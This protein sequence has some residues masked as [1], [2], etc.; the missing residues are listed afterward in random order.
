MTTIIATNYM[1]EADEL[2]NKIAIINRGKLIVYEDINILKDS[3]KGD[4]ID[5][6]LDKDIEKV[7]NVLDKRKWVNSVEEYD[8]ILRIYVHKG[9][10]KI[11]R[12]IDI[13]KKYG[14]LKSITLRKPS[15]DDVFIH[16]CGESLQ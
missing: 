15:L 7:K 3:L 16:Y 8:N 10:E 14:K 9:E 4:I 2:C 6:K 12:V 11:E 1:Q 5:I 13:I